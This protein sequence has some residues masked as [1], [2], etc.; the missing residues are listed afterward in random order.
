MKNYNNFVEKQSKERRVYSTM[1]EA[2]QA[3]RPYFP[4]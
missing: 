1:E 3:V 4:K 2:R